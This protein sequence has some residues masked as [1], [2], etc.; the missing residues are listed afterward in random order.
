MIFSFNKV[1]L[2]GNVTRDPELK[3][4]PTGKAV[5]SFGLAMNS[6]YLDR[7]SNE[8]KDKA[9]FIDVVFWEKKAEMVSEK[10]LKGDKVY[11]EGSLQT[12][13]W[14]DKNG[15][16]HYK[17]EVRGDE[18]SPMKDRREDKGYNSVPQDDVF[19]DS[20]GNKVEDIVIPEDFGEVPAT[21]VSEEK[22]EDLPF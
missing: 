5:V 15:T 20:S 16:K 4:T 2:L 22:T 11:V 19:T 1:M 13:S 9:E 6:R 3:Y 10:I 18:F 14:E 17:T 21:P 8:W 7:Q 12:R